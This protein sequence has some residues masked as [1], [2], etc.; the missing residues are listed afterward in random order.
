M[1]CN[2][3]TELIIGSDVICQHDI[4]ILKTAATQS[5][6]YLAVISLHKCVIALL[7]EVNYECNMLGY[8]LE[9]VLLRI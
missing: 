8:V 5:C 3:E 1:I 4:I 9:N 6:A 7:H 2:L